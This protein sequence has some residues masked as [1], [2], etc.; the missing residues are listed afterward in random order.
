VLRVDAMLTKHL[1]NGWSFGLT[2]G[3]LDQVTDDTG[4]ALADDLNGFRGRSFGL[5]PSVSYTHHFSKTSSLNFGFRYLFNF[6]THNQMNGD[7]LM[8]TMS[9]T[10]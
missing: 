4:S 9:F 2:G 3:I 6:A 8:L 7:P 1:A 5:G 10:P